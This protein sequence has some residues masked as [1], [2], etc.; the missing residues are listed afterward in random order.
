[1]GK[2]R[3]RL[4]QLLVD[5]ELACSLESARAAIL[6]GTV[7]VDQQRVDKPGTQTK[8]SAE[9]S[10]KEGSSKYV[11]RG[12]LKLEAAIAAFKVNVS[13]KACLDLGASTGGFTDCLLQHGARRVY[14]IDVGRGQLDWRLR[15]DHRVV[16]QEGINARFLKP[17]GLP[18]KIDV[19][20]VDLSFIS[21]R[22]VFPVLCGFADSEI[23][24][25][26]KPQFEAERREVGRG[27]LIRSPEKQKE[28]LERVKKLAVEQE[29]QILDTLPS[30]IRG[31]K[32]NQEYFLLLRC[33][34]DH[35]SDASAP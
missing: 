12:G 11:S 13:G 28:I 10:I 3:E 1:M 7:F 21:L 27:G 35:V 20:T 33:G 26:V 17:S 23:L 32:G 25:L 6:A 5:R 24:T 16:V 18:E 19:V 29:L 22:V 2:S 14:A 4:D 9:I 8:S 30:P 34:R 31:Q 15:N